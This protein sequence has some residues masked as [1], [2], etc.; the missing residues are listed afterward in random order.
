MT[1]IK[2]RAVESNSCSKELLDCKIH[3]H[4]DN[5]FP[6]AAG[7]AS[8]ASGYACLVFCLAKL[9][10]I[11]KQE[12]SDIARMGSGSACRSI[13]GGFVQ[14]QKGTNYDGKDSIAVQI[15]P[16]SHWP[17]LHVLIL[18]VNDC[19]KK[20]GSTNGMARTILT[21]D[22]IKYR[23]EKCVP[24]R[25]NQMTQAIRDRNFNKFA[26]ITMKDSNQ[27]HAICLDT[28]PPV[29]YMN[30]VSHEIVNYV[31]QFN[32]NEGETKIAYTFDAGANACLYLLEK[33]VK[34]VLAFVNHVFPN[35]NQKNVE[36][37]RGIPVEY[38][39]SEFVSIFFGN[40]LNIIN[41][42]FGV[43]SIFWKIFIVCLS[44]YVFLRKGIEK[45]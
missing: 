37:L 7:L 34:K 3:V 26:E 5:N 35:D 44:I 23:V 41:G 14:W 6:T 1:E 29:V 42:F 32:K 36:Y 38:S 27:F 25:V 21:S 40:F 17:E 33:N 20:T 18:V 4:S 45:A 22:L 43:F 10:G 19:K 11:K 15:A 30:D 8:S 24:G 16:A 2:K 28:Y 9:Y 39:G 12:I 31:H 13:Y